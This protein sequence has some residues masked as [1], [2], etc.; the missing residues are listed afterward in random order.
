[1]KLVQKTVSKHR[2]PGRRHLI[3]K[4]YPATCPEVIMRFGEDPGALGD[5]SPLLKNNRTLS[6]HSC[7]SLARQ[8]RDGRSDRLA[9]C[10]LP[11][12]GAAL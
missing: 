3:S 8:N 6:A 1:M 11:N 12:L 9:F 2:R 5:E 7:C 4:S 10:C